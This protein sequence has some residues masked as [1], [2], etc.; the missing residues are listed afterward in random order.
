MQSLKNIV[1]NAAMILALLL[2]LTVSATAI[3]DLEKERLKENIALAKQGDAGSQVALGDAYS[4][5]EGVEK[6]LTQAFY[7]HQKAADQGYAIGQYS[8]GWAYYI[9]E[10]TFLVQDYPK[11]L[12]WFKKAA[13][14]NLNI[15]QYVLG[16][17][18][19]DGEGV[20]QNRTTAKEWYGKACDN[21]DEVGCFQYKR[22]NEEGY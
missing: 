14:Q 13:D 15:A 19:E 17:I 2:G 9:G 1:I 12:Y 8:V 7:W 3:S 4:K 18:Y 5:G 20:R 16:K 22:L 6:D 21:G 11:A 10:Y